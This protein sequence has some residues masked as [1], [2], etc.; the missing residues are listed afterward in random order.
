MRSIEDWPVKKAAERIRR[1]RKQREAALAARRERAQAFAKTLAEELGAA[2]ESLRE[3][4]GFG[5]TFETWRSY[6]EDSDIDLH[7]TTSRRRWARNSRA[8]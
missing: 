7:S 6:R 5:S 8:I 4:F 2:D 1:K 3:V